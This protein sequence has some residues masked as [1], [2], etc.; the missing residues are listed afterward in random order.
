LRSLLRIKQRLRI[1]AEQEIN[2]Y[3]NNRTNAAAHSKT[4]SAGS[5][6]VFNVFALSSSLPEHLLRIVKLFAR[7]YNPRME[8]MGSATWKVQAGLALNC[9]GSSERTGKRAGFN[10][11][12]SHLSFDMRHKGGLS[13]TLRRCRV[14]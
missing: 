11:A 1:A 13:Y 14:R 7:V 6:S 12:R 9:K 3:E 10:G 8:L 5:A 2:N 4:P